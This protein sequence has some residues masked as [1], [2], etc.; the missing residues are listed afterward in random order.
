ME[1]LKEMEGRKYDIYKSENLKK[2]PKD[3]RPHYLKAQEDLVR[4]ALDSYELPS[5]VIKVIKAMKKSG[6]VEVTTTRM[7]KI[8]TN[9]AN[10]AI[11]LD[12][13]AC[14][15]DGDKVTFRITLLDSKH[16]TYFYKMQ[17]ADKLEHVL[18]LKAT[19]T[20]FFKADPELV[21][22]H[23]KKAADIYQKIN[24]YYN[25][26]DSTNNYAKEDES[27]EA[28]QKTNAELRG[29]KLSTF[30]N[31]TVCKHKMG[32][33]QSVL[34]ITEQVL[35]EQMDPRNVKAMY[36]RAYALIKTQEFESAVVCLQRLLKVDPEHGEGKKLLVSARKAHSRH[37][38]EESSKYAALFK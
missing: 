25:F 27:T 31:L 9:F 32:E 11:G 35:S 30:N 8:R 36:F 33:W 12:Q 26:G 4:L 14:C 3:A 19:A 22:N 7:D 20:R 16:P 13:Y 34:G 18:R 2:V 17:V 1:E 5:L 6:V 23:L 38:E 15:S 21:K 24:G 37:V 29:I 10:E 28:Y